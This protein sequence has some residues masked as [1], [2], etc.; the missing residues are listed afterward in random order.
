LVV[1]A[2][3]KGDEEMKGRN[4]RVGEAGSR[5]IKIFQVVLRSLAAPSFAESR[6]RAKRAGLP[7]LCR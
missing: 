2:T 4:G 7:K 3:V 1:A 6:A 5:G